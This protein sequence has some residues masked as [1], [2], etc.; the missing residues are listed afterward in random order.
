MTRSTRIQQYSDNIII[1]EHQN[2]VLANYSPVS[3]N[4][5][6][7]SRPSDAQIFNFNSSFRRPSE[8]V[9]SFLRCFG[10]FYAY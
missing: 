9:K 3:N 5:F 6:Y 1:I 2:N 7:F 8:L 10:D 4:C